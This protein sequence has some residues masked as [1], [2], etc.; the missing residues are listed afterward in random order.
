MARLT[1]AL[2][3]LIALVSAVPLDTASQLKLSEAQVSDL[4]AAGLNSHF[5][6][7]SSEELFTQSREAGYA[8]AEAA[9][10]ACEDVWLVFARGTFEPG[11][12]NNLGA[13]V[14]YP[15][16]KLL[17]DALGKRYGAT[18]VDYNNDVAGYLSGGDAKGSAKMAQMIGSKLSSCPNTK[19]V[20]SGY[21]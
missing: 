19:I 11:M 2:L 7:L 15:F 17:S 4:F 1:A 3:G 10:Q 16:N 8:E 21:R 5:A 9:A 13:V 6:T 20:A 18:G 12:T 14:G